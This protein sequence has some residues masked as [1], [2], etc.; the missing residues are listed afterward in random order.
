MQY[1]PFGDLGFNISGL[2][3]GMMRL[4]CRPDGEIDYEE[5]SRMVD[6]AIQG[7]VNYFDT[8][9]R[10]PGNEVAVGKFLAKGHR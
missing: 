7:G 6:T 5:T 9:W 8:A 2:G 1:V 10:Y 3:F 4:P